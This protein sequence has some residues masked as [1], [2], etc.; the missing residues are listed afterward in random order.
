MR[1]IWLICGFMALGLGLIGVI[2]P[3]LPTVPFM[4]LAA[5][6]FSRSSE[7]LH[8]WILSHPRLG[9]PVIAW[10]ERGA[11]SLFAKRISSVS[12]LG[13]WLLSLFLGL[14]PTI[15]AIQAAAMIGAAAFIWSRPSA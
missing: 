8:N 2:T 3:V 5:F 13:A 11:I 7:R 9:P 6:C 12:M 4:I 14:A 15:L 1:L 10:R